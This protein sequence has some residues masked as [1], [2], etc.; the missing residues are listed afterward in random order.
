MLTT[1]KKRKKICKYK[2]EIDKFLTIS[3][4]EKVFQS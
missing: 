2:E 4:Q 3:V 1:T